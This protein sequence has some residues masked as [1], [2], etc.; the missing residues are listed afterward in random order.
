MIET[1]N[2]GAK[3]Y[4]IQSAVLNGKTL[5][6][7]WI[8]HETLVKGGK[9]RLEMGSSPNKSWGSTPEMAPPSMS[10]VK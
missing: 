3:N 10:T 7:P 8:W 9:L 1:K 6:R 2:N 4:F 5:D